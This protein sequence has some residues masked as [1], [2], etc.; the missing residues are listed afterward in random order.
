MWRAYDQDGSGSVDIDEFKEIV[1]AVGSGSW[2][3]DELQRMF[4]LIDADGSGEVS[5]AEFLAFMARLTTGLRVILH[6][7]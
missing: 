4:A 6:T 2:S 3:D 5:E 7:K 1:R